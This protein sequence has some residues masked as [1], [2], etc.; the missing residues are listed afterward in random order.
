MYLENVMS[1]LFRCF[2]KHDKDKLLES[3]HKIIYHIIESY[4]TTFASRYEAY[5]EVEYKDVI[6]GYN[7]PCISEDLIFRII[8][9]D[10]IDNIDDQDLRDYLLWE[11]I[12][13]KYFND[14]IIDQDE[15]EAIDNFI[16]KFQNYQRA[17]APPSSVL[18]VQR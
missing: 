16:Y 3:N 17:R 8:E 18:L 4:G 11:N 7:M 2:E 10:I 6:G 5:Y 12:I 14:G 9:N 15:V 13:I 1:V